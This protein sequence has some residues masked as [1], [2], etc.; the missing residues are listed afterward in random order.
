MQTEAQEVFD[1]TR[2]RRRRATCTARASSPTPASSPAGWSN[3]ASRMVQIFTGGGQ[4]WDDHGDIANHA[5]RRSTVDQPIA[6]LLKD[7]KARLARRHAG[8]LGRRVRPHADVAKARNGRDHNN[9]GFSVWLA[10]GGVKGGM[11]Y[12]ATDE[13]GFAAAEKQD[14]RPRP[15][16]DDPAPDGHRPREA[17][18]PLLGPRLPPDGRQRHRERRSSREVGRQTLCPIT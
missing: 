2:K 5:T 11:V 8:P 13:F 14:A 16:R 18:L 15:A 1:L 9:H 10:G 12:G 17:D 4:P 3:A 6:A 7:L